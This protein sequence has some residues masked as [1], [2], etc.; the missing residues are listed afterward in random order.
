[1]LRTLKDNPER[2][3][4]YNN[5]ISGICSNFEVSRH[6]INIFGL[7]VINGAQ[8]IKTI[9]EAELSALN[10]SN[11]YV[12]FKL[13]TTKNPNVKKNIIQASNSQTSIVPADFRANDEIQIFLNDKLKD[14][15]YLGNDNKSKKLFYVNKRQQID[16]K[17]KKKNI[18]IDLA[19]LT[20]VLAAIKLGPHISSATSS[21]FDIEKNY[22]KIYG[23]EGAPLDSWNTSAIIET[24]AIIFVWKRVEYL[25]KQEIKKLKNETPE[26]ID[27][28]AH[29]A[30][31]PRFHIIYSYFY[32]LENK[33]PSEIK[34]IYTNIASGKVFDKG[35]NFIDRWFPII[36][37]AFTTIFHTEKSFNFRN[38]QRQ[39]ESIENLKNQLNILPPH[40]LEFNENLFK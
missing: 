11:V 31:L 26:K 22:W 3:F 19:T 35:N 27:K 37:M 17:T 24:A 28:P 20:K 5:G 38:W 18:T 1:M 40:L 25:R 21:L 23:D 29:L 8:T 15:K 14:Y 30:L 34:N 16:A 6:N 2:F 7:Q 12:L 39:K 4:I 10:L 9:R 13:T 36:I 32:L 33:Y